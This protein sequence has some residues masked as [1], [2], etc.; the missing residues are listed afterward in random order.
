MTEVVSGHFS[1]PDET[2]PTVI[3]E[4]NAAHCQTSKNTIDFQAHTH[5]LKKKPC[6]AHK[7]ALF[8]NQA[9][10]IGNATHRRHI[11]TNT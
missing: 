3:P 2:Q 8:E 11:T 1:S 4:K 7:Q 10:C 5:C 6:F 9:Y